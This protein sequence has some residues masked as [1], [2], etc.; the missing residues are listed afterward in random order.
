MDDKEPR[1]SGRITISDVAEALNISKTTVSR[2]ISGKGRIGEETRKKVLDYIETHNYKPSPLAKGLAQSKTYNIGWVMP[3][4]S[5]VTD[6][7][8]FQRCMIGISE[9]VA[10][11][12]YDILLI[13]V[14]EDD[15]SQLQ[16]VVENHKIDGLILGRTLIRDDRI[17]YLKQTDLP[18]VAIGS[19]EEPNV[20]QIDNDHIAACRELTS[21]LIMK[22]MKKFHKLVFPCRVEPRDGL[23]EN[24]YFGFGNENA[25]YRDSSFLS[26]RKLERQPVRHIRA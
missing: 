23:V 26:A 4:D 22:G 12:D 24:E 6:L 17:K 15:M 8:F 20:A 25:R 3:G 11:Q 9:A 1:E 16:R 5:E 10:F 13:M 7:P 2:A 14:Y 19:T 21:I 18:F